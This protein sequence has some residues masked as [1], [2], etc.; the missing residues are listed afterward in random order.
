MKRIKVRMGQVCHLGQ[1]E[2]ASMKVKMLGIFEDINITLE[3]HFPGHPVS[4]LC[5][6]WSHFLASLLSRH[7]AAAVMTRLRRLET[8]N[9]P[10]RTTFNTFKHQ[11]S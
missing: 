4:N 11:F 6:L 1:V 5:F 7:R 9:I 3:C 8:V 2:V 10:A